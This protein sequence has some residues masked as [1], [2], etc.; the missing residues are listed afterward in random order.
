MGEFTFKF[1]VHGPG[2]AYTDRPGSRL[3]DSRS[4]RITVEADNLA[5]AR[6]EFNSRKR[7]TPQYSYIKERSHEGSSN[8]RVKIERITGPGGDLLQVS[9]REARVHLGFSAKDTPAPRSSSVR[10][11]LIDPRQLVKKPGI[12]PPKKKLMSKGG[13][14]FKGVF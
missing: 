4:G 1:T 9:K 5:D 2:Y 13:V 14:S 11:P 6:K 10:P 12:W 3:T 8:P 7:G